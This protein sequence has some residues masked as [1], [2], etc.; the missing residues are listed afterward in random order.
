M[1]FIQG[2]G[3]DKVIEELQ[4]LRG[5]SMNGKGRG[6]SGAQR[7]LAVARPLPVTVP[8]AGVGEAARGLLTG[9]FSLGN[10]TLAHEEGSAPDPQYPAPAPAKDGVTGSMPPAQESTGSGTGATSA[11]LPG[12]AQLSSV[13][14]RHRRYFDS[15]ARIGQQV[16][17]A[18]TYAHQR[19]II[20]RDV[21]PSNLLL[22]ASGVVWVTD[23][24]LAKTDEDG[25]TRTGDLLGTFLY[26]A[27]ERFRGESDARSDV[28][29][30]G[31]TLYELLV[32]RPAFTAPDRLRIVE[33][34][35]EHV[36]PAPR[37]LDP[38]IPRDLETIVLTAIAKDPKRRYQTADL[39]GD[40]L[41][42]FLDGQ[43]IRARRVRLH[44]RLWLW[45]RRNP[46]WAAMLTAV[47]SLLLAIA[48]VSSFLTLQLNVA[49]RA[50][51]DEKRIANENLWE[52]LLAQAE[53]RRLSQRRGQRFTALEAIRK[54]AALPVPPGHS[55]AELRNAA[56]ACL[57]LP[58]LETI[59][60]WEGFPL[61]SHGVAFDVTLERYA[62]GDT[63]GT[64]RVCRTGDGA[65]IAT[66]PS[67]GQ[68]VVHG[69]LSFSP[70][71]RFLYR[72]GIDAPPQVWR[73]RGTEAALGW[74]APKNSDGMAAFAADSSLLAIPYQDGSVR[75]FDTA[76]GKETA[77]LATGF[78][79]VRLA[80]CPGQA[81]LAV[82][83]GNLIK[84]L[85]RKTGKVLG[86]LKH[87]GTV[88]WI[89]WHPG[90]ELLASACNDLKI[91]LWRATEGKLA[92]P[93]LE[94]HVTPG[95]QVQFTREGDRVI[96]NDWSSALRV[97]DTATGR[98]LLLT[99]CTWGDRATRFGNEG[100]AEVVGRNLRTLRFASGRELRTLTARDGS[101]GRRFF[102]NTSPSP[103]GRFLLVNSIDR[104]AFVDWST[105]A[106]VAWLPFREP[107]AI[108]FEPC[109]AFVTSGPDGLLRW[110]TQT[111]PTGTWRVG[112][113]QSLSQLSNAGW[114]GSSADGSVLAIPNFGA[115]A[116]VLHRSLSPDP[117]P[118]TRESNRV[119]PRLETLRGPQKDVRNCAVSPDGRWV[120]TGNH[121]DLGIGVIVWDAQ[122][123]R[124]VKNLN[125]GG[126][127]VR[128]SP[129]GNWLLTSGG[130]Y[131][132][133]WTVGTWEEGPPLK[134]DDHSVCAGAAFT[135][136][137][138]MLAL[139]GEE[140]QVRLVEVATGAEIAR[141]TVPEQTNLAPQCFS[142]DGSHLV[143]IGNN[144][145]MYIWDLRLLRGELAE[146]GLDWGWP[147][148]SP[149]ARP[150]PP[151]KVDVQLG[152]SRP[153]LKVA[154]YTISLAHLPLNP[155][156]Y[157]Q[158]ALAYRELKRPRDAIADY[159]AFLAMT[160][161][162]A[163]RH[164][165]ILSRRLTN[166]VSLND[167]AAALADLVA[168]ASLDTRSLP[169]PD[170]TARYSNDFARKLLTCPVKDR[171]VDKAFILARRAMD[172]E[173]ENTEYRG[174][175]G[176]ACYRLGHYRDAAI[177]F[178]KNAH[179]DKAEHA[180]FANYLL[181][182]TYHRLGEA[183]KAMTCL[184]RAVRWHD[185]HRA[186]L[187]KS[188]ET[189]LQNVHAEAEAL[190]ASS[191]RL[192]N[193]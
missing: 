117:G 113:P 153:E 139:S 55:R 172:L 38:R 115:G 185:A 97:W 32:L 57:V 48:I 43:P 169:W 182:M 67:T 62:N 11:L 83:G 187:S 27:P 122:T 150:L 4:R 36:P 116:V 168:L 178:Q 2:Q 120:A 50:A 99:T 41:R 171:Q 108:A 145:L 85:N 148:F 133:L 10:L 126:S 40:D 69:E 17:S 162:S 12:N 23:F 64:V 61:G 131:Y 35:K 6:G 149:A 37:A 163:P 129:D 47:A 110:P 103:D 147:E 31:L 193:R 104:L 8:L 21:K 136:D 164:A 77:N 119:T 76:T 127:L 71:G 63:D 19:G 130:G 58:D 93:P 86:E 111:K 87:P 30:L 152:L 183:R 65:L 14:S 46:G 82:A 125:I 191:A 53:S 81:H 100:G 24:G 154:T 106:E 102:G 165:E 44:E 3:L 101:V 190:L 142:G 70:D 33:L 5:S 7:D 34:V 156:A 20:H 157:L 92:L 80:F 186:T 73:L 91:R 56:L 89:D 128:F 26:M 105:G 18:L 176:L 114:H 174:T 155:D 177:A 28:Y 84:I 124:P 72:R 15:V 175:L 166:Y 138:Q 161:A 173:P 9:R 181:A 160:P 112:P 51:E 151:L 180:A 107:T 135:S 146:L 29:A 75:V 88:G 141:L 143:A 45:A 167:D 134:K 66:L 59:R 1:Q 94:G 109:G 54:A 132:Q 60:E 123:S 68:R 118:D 144:K 170:S 95:L 74:E 49:L 159:S 192:S 90:G 25:L 158:R 78:H 121:W 188:W 79:P 189:L 42:R 16:A 13:E 96:S 137:G 52:S 98:M 184:E 179:E 22:D 140:S 39:M